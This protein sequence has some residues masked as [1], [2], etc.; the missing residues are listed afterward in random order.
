MD[1]SQTQTVAPKYIFL[2]S[3]GKIL[4]FLLYLHTLLKSY[5][6]ERL[7]TFLMCC[8]YLSIII[9]LS[10]SPYLLKIQTLYL[11]TYL[12]ATPQLLLHQL[13]THIWY[14][15]KNNMSKNEGGKFYIHGQRVGVRNRLFRSYIS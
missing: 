1:I 13:S 5:L 14:D 8:I 6:S 11:Q 3:S 15:Q 4:T 10:Y 2:D 9:E 7:K 12:Y